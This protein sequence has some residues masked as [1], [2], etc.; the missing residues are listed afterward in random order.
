MEGE[1][2]LRG[3]GGTPGGIKHFVVGFIM[4]VVGGFLLMNQVKVHTGIWSFFGFG[5]GFGISLIPFLF[6]V[7]LL[8]FNGKS[9]IGWF[10]TIGGFLVILAGVIANLQ[11]YFVP[12][13]L[14]NTIIMLVLLVGG[15]ALIFRSLRT[16]P[17]S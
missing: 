12:T 14:F 11:I 3:A 8:F 15:L 6:G 7:A 13:S 5:G 9:I 2:R 16:F 1:K 17:E 10:L 4:A